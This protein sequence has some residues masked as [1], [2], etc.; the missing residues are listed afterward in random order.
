MVEQDLVEVVVVG[1]QFG[2]TPKLLME[3]CSLMVV[4]EHLKVEVLVSL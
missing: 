2:S 4:G 1:L 3:S